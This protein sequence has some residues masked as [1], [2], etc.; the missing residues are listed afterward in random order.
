MS[1][2]RTHAEPTGRRGNPRRESGIALVLS[3]L[4]LIAVSTL[5]L[6]T[7]QTAA[8][9]GTVAGFQNQE[10]IAFYAAEAGIADAR[11]VVRNMGERSQVPDYP[12]DFPNSANP[13]TLSAASEFVG[14]QPVYY[15]DPNPP[16]AAPI[17]YVGEG[18]P[19]TE[20]CNMTLG[21][22]IY[23]HT[24]W[25]V[26]VVGESPSGDQKRLEVVATRLLAVGY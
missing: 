2:I 3:I 13:E 11:A 19:C 16:T 10:Q 8:S 25:Q 17:M 18:A 9:D 22:L 14:D 15:A 4:L 23:N 6:S 1:E 7:M 5:A 20:G 21:G 24:M 12:G 26:N